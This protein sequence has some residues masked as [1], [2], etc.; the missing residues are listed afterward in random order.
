MSRAVA[1]LGAILLLLVGTAGLAAAWTQEGHDASRTARVPE[2]GPRTDDVAFSLNLPGRLADHTLAQTEPLVHNGSAY[3]PLSDVD[4]LE[5][6][7]TDGVVRVDLDTATLEPLVLLERGRG[8]ASIAIDEG[9]L[10][11]ATDEALS[12]HELAD[13]AEIWS[14]PNP[15]LSSQP[16]DWGWC[17]AP[18]V[19]GDLV[20]HSCTRAYRDPPRFEPFIAA[21]DAASGEAAWQW[22]PEPEGNEDPSSEGLQEEAPSGMTLIGGLSVAGSNLFASGLSE[23]VVGPSN[24][25]DPVPCGEEPFL[26]ANLSLFAFEAESPQLS[27]RHGE[28]VVDMQSPVST[29]G[30]QMPIETLAGISLHP[31]GTA[32]V[33]YTQIQ[34]EVRALTPTERTGGETVVW[35]EEIGEHDVRTNFTV[36][37]FAL[38]EDRLYTT[39]TETVYG[40]D[41]E[42]PEEQW[43]QTLD[44][45]ADE[46]FGATDL[47]LAEDALYVGAYKRDGNGT[48]L[49][50]L[51]PDTGQPQW[52]HRLPG[53]ADGS[54]TSH[55]F[56]FGDGVLVVAGTDRSL[57]AIGTTAASLDPDV[58]VSSAYPDLG[59]TVRVNLSGT[60]SG[61][62][63]EATRFKADWGDGTTTSWQSSP[64]LTHRYAESG[65]FDARFVVGNDANQTASTTQ[66]FHAGQQAPREPSWLAERFDEGNE[67]MTF[68]VIGVALA[69][70]GGLIGVGRRSRKR[71][72]LER[73]LE[74]LEEGF[75]ETEARPSECES[76]L[77]NRKARARSLALDGYLREDQVPVIE[78][79]AEELRRELRT[80]AVEEEFGFLPHNLVLKARKMLEDGEVTELEAEA[81][82]AALE[83]VDGLTAQREAR[84]RER[85][86]AWHGRDGGR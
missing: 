18:A 8:I 81:F 51:D 7:S 26:H 34:E 28:R 63:G 47:V 73:E 46:V 57:R 27:W 29:P 84:V 15:T 37:G 33:V 30:N 82:L 86:E 54:S 65:D 4:T 56:A 52:R 75:E 72:R 23:V 9:R 79:R 80:D 59:E 50:A 36:S 53:A 32:Q 76:F 45:E 43:S 39:S 42:N 11:V 68:G 31:T 1:I 69:V 55:I 24:C 3:L 60:G 16:P 58:S 14:L 78:N 66:T 10:F 48:T 70:G 61:A 64:L 25:L 40:L 85:I 2:A 83:D 44:P 49:Y 5:G 13:G 71:S 20:Y 77:D 6:R 67:D 22:T 35:R 21:V 38:G 19:A 41:R 62:Q 74:A 17:T 12:A